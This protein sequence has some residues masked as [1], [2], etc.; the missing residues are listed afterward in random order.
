MLYEYEIH[1]QI[2]VIKHLVRMNVTSKKRN[3]LNRVHD[4]K[5]FIDIM[6]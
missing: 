1:L 2:H 6:F 3:R 4:I 5:L